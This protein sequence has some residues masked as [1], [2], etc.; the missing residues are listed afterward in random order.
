MSAVRRHPEPL[1]LRMA[2][3][4]ARYIGFGTDDIPP[5]PPAVAEQRPATP[6]TQTKPHLSLVAPVSASRTTIG[7]KWR[8][9]PRLRDYQAPLPEHVRVARHEAVRGL[10]AARAGATDLAIHHFALAARSDEVDLTAVPGF[11]D[12]TRGQMTMA[13]EAYEQAGRYRDAAALDAHIATIFRPSL[14]G[15]TLQ[16]VHPRANQKQA[17]ST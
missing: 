16:P 8:R 10:C 3:A 15:I 5:L 9:H 17:A 14:V 7:D 11:W 6:A 13:V 2:C 12:L 1:V 4:I